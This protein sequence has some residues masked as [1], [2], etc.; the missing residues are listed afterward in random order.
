MR[1]ERFERWKKIG[2]SLSQSI[3]KDNLSLVSAGMA[4]YLLLGLFPAL[5][6]FVLV[7]SLLTDSAQIQQQ[8]QEF[9]R[10]VPPAVKSTIISQVETISQKSGQAGFGAVISI[11]IAIWSGSKAAKALVKGL[12]IAYNE[13]ESRGFVGVILIGLGLTVLGVMTG[14]IAIVLLVVI[15][16]VMSFLT[17]G[18]LTAVVIEILRWLLMVFLFMT[19]LALLYRFAPDR[20]PPEWKWVTPGAVMATLLW[21]IASATFSWYLANFGNFDE[22]YGSFGA[23]IVFLLL[24]F[25]S[26]FLILFGAEF[27]QEIERQNVFKEKTVDGSGDFT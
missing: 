22:V 17:L 9:G 16:I 18:G 23:P 7:F 14:I 20:K 27:N 11:L 3:A 10:I 2:E 5:I 1:A 15:P 26:S 8:I 24:V 6:A 13:E 19:I 4:Y 21:I 12:N 25:L